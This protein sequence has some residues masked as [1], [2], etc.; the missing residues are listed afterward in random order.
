MK[1][2]AGGFRRSENLVRR[3]IGVEIHDIGDQLGR[4]SEGV[5]VKGEAAEENVRHLLELCGI[6]FRIALRMGESLVDADVFGLSEIFFHCGVRGQFGGSEWFSAAPAGGAGREK[7]GHEPNGQPFH[8]RQNASFERQN[9]R[10]S[11]APRFVLGFCGWP[12]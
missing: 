8:E 5:A 6:Q 11:V 9:Q 1:P 2:G 10:V 7:Q 12:E 3:G 4:N